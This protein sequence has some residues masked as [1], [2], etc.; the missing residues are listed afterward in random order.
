MQY[1]FLLVSVLYKMATP[2]RSKS[3][4]VDSSTALPPVLV[5]YHPSMKTLAESLVDDTKKKL[6]NLTEGVIMGVYMLYMHV[7]PGPRSTCH[8]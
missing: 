5:L 2:H 7:C 3:G 6:G 8:T 4:N 1:N